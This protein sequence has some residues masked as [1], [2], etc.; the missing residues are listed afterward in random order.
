MRMILVG[1]PGSGK[2][3]Q[4]KLI[5]QFFKAP[6]ISTG[7]L[8]RQEVKQGTE[9]GKQAQV[10]MQAGQLVPDEIMLKMV[11]NKLA[12]EESFILDGFPR[13]KAQAEHLDETLA[14]LGKPLT[15]VAN[16]MVDDEIVVKR[17]KE[18]GRQDDTEEIIR[19]RLKVYHEQTEPVTGHY[20][21]Q[22]L[23]EP[24]EAEGS[25][26]QVGYNVITQMNSRLRPQGC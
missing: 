11:D 8:L 19:E 4:A 23:L 17:L 5:H 6:H 14:R 13:S 9:L 26:P 16:L 7:D 22:S 18:R 3:T 21:L 20:Q 15:A 24:V 25:V 2:G 12:G 10:Y 1:P